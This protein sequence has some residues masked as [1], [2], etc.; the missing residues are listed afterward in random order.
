MPTKANEGW[1]VGRRRK[2]PGRIKKDPTKLEPKSRSQL[3]HPQVSREQG[4]NSSVNQLSHINSSA[5]NQG[6]LASKQ[7][8]PNRPKRHATKQTN[9]ARPQRKSWNQF[10]GTL[11]GRLPSMN[12]TDQA[13]VKF[14]W[15]SSVVVLRVEIQ[16][17]NLSA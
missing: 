4:D 6:L 5:W 7:R 2:K 16:N 13:R 15:R 12:T 17:T 14:T 1:Q 10:T 8:A 11:G 9:R 3:N